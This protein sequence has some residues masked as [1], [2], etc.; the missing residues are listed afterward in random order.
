MIK[1]TKSAGSNGF[2]LIELLVVVLIIGILAT[3][4]LPQYH[5]AV[6]KAR[7]VQVRTAMDSLEKSNIIYHLANGRYAAD[8]DTFELPSSGCT[9]SD[10]KTRFTCPWG[11]CAV[12]NDG[13]NYSCG[14]TL[15]SGDGLSLE[16][17]P[18][19]GQKQ[20][21]ASGV[22]ASASSRAYKLCNSLP[23]T[24]VPSNWGCGSNICIRFVLQQ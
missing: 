20:C 7:F 13:G 11:N 19:S 2:T 21:I 1:N 18:N 23:H 8:F 17:F 12:Y 9:L 3:V 24:G 10:D 16:H 15:Q 14:I 6:D 22:N 5:K 4:A